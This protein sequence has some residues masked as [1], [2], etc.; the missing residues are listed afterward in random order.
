MSSD[1]STSICRSWSCSSLTIFC[2]KISIFWLLTLACLLQPQRMI[3]PVSTGKRYI[4]CISD[5]N[6][7]TPNCRS[8]GTPCQC[9]RQAYQRDQRDAGPIFWGGGNG[10]RCSRVP[11]VWMA[12]CCDKSQLRK[13]LP[14]QHVSSFSDSLQET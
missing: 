7:A 9:I 3:A 4:F 2:D 12:E 10:F 14:W 5:H 11:R 13:Q 1:C 8:D 6:S